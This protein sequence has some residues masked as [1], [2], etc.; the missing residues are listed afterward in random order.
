MEEIN[1]LILLVGHNPMPLYISICLLYT[2]AAVT[3]QAG[4]WQ[5]VAGTRFAEE[6]GYRVV[7]VTGLF[8]KG[9]LEIKVVF[10]TQGK[11]S[12]MWLGDLVSNEYKAPGYACLLYTSLPLI[13]NATCG[14]K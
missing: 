11:I 13:R 3:S 5:K 2:S 6:A 9:S 10:N 4:N 7:F 12:G 8:E 14:L 1:N